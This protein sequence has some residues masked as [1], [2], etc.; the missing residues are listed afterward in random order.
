MRPLGK[1]LGGVALSFMCLFTSIGYAAISENLVIS[2]SAEII[3]PQYDE[4]V[5]T[6]VKTLSSN[7]S[8]ETHKDVPL[9]NVQST[10]SGSAGQTIVYKITA[11]NYSKT[12]TYVYTGTQISDVYTDVSDK[13]TISA[14]L[15]EE[16]K[17]P[18]MD[19]KTYNSVEGIP[20][21]PDE[22]IVFYATYTL[23][24]NVSTAEI[25]VNFSFKPV[26]YSVTYMSDNDIYAIDCIFDNSI[27]YEVREEGPDKGDLVFAN[28]VNANADVVY[29]YPAGNTNSYTLSAKWD[30]VYLIIFVDN[31]G[32]VI[33]E[34][35]FTD[36]STKLSPEG[37]A[38]IDAKLAELQSNADK[39][40]S[41]SWTDYDIS[42]ANGNITVRAVYT[43]TGN[44]KLTPVDGDGDGITDYYQVDAV[45]KLDDPTIIPGRINGLDVAVVN[46]LYLNANNFDYGAGVNTIEIGEGVKRINHN[47]LAYTSDLDK[48][49]LPS[50]I[51][52]ID[53]NVFSRNSGSDKKVLTIEFNGT[54]AEWQAIEKNS[55]WHNG[56]KD[57]S[58]VK[59]SDG[60]FELD[61][62][63]LG[64]GGYTWDAHSY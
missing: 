36:S 42:N 51:E 32:N 43:Y 2:G 47:A 50:T 56:L 30:N 64:L 4:I 20:V 45:D 10:I 58:T 57:G 22:E 38:I 19:R 34:E 53:K 37:Q 25:L 55:D 11:H 54:M 26:I 15:D 21:A 1:I 59:C 46:K 49:K 39:D 28:W 24:A 60:Y 33:Y 8:S 31:K 40:M 27:E 6:E 35:S 29:S 44:L 3:P 61:R 17:K 52:Y 5:I 62:G 63:F 48:V 41:V 9:T 23:N 18:L 12:T 7:V 14:S 16:N 13:L